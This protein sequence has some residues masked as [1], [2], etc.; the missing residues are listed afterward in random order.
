ML[1]PSDA[2]QFGGFVVA[3]HVDVLGHHDRVDALIEGDLLDAGLLHSGAGSG[4]DP[5]YELLH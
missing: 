2:S 4:D 3:D 5:F 1:N